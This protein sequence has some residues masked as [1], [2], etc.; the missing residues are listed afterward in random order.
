ML[1]NYKSIVT[2]FNNP[3]KLIQG[4]Y[5]GMNLGEIWGMQ[6]AGLFQTQQEINGWA[7]Q[8]QVSEAS[9]SFKPGDVKYVDQNG[10]GIIN[11]GLNTLDAPG[12][13]KIIGNSTPRFQFGI[14]GYAEWKG[15]DMSFLIQGVARREVYVGQLGTFRGAANGAFHTTIYEGHMDYWRDASS[16]LGA[17]PN[18]Y[19]PN[20]YLAFDNQNQKNFRF[21]TDRYMQNAAYIRLKN[22]QIGYTMPRKISEKVL[23]SKA[24]IYLS[25]ENLLTGSKL[26]F[27]DP[28]AFQGNTSRVGSQYPLSRIFSIGLNINF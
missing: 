6:T 13:R 25:G 4:Y 21:P 27:F 24:R 5:E 26:M 2:K 3:S 15:F 14:S 22:L 18:G 23:I 1:S 28:E 11:T 12:D 17:N 20:S 10:D 19:F 9:Y 8:F 16:P 7:N